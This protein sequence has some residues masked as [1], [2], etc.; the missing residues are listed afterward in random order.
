ML[1]MVHTP[2]CGGKSLRAAFEDTYG[3]KLWKDYANPFVSSY[4]Y[5]FK[6]KVKL[7]CKFPFLSHI[8]VIFG[9][10]CLDRYSFLRREDLVFGMMFRNPVELVASRY[11][12]EMNKYKSQQKQGL[13]EFIQ[14]NDLT[15]FY[16]ALLGRFR[17]SDL[18]Y[19]V[20]TERFEESLQLFEKIF[21]RRLTYHRR[22]ITPVK[23]SNETYSE[24]LQELGIYTDVL[25][26]QEENMELYN[27]AVERF[28][29]LLKSQ[30]GRD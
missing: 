27:R 23:G 15:H 30:T 11:F 29:F 10:F 8:E 4:W 2:K 6:R 3:N 22:N 28:D 26:S 18:N 20:I 13:L 17:I 19:I 1:V 21:H 25:A 7:F 12:Y 16:A 5:H 9:H 14:N 24:L